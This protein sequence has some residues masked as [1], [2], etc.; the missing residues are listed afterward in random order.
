MF[1]TIRKNHQFLMLV[2]VILTILGFI[3][4]YIRANPSQFGTND[5]LSIYGRVVQRAEIDSQVRSY[6]LALALGL[7]DFV[8]DLGGLGEDENISLNNYLL[9]LLLIE[10]QSTEL[11][12]RPSDDQVLAMIKSLA[13]LQTDGAF[14][15]AKYT[16][17]VQDQLAPR[18]LTERQMEDIV[19]DSIRVKELKAI[20]TSP[21]AIGEGEVQM[22]A[23]IY[24]PVTAQVIH[25]DLEKYL[26]DS[27]VT[28]EEISAFYEKNREGLKAPETRSI[29]YVVFELP[30]QDQKLEGKDRANALQKLADQAVGVA[31]SIHDG[32]SQGSDFA[33]IAGKQSLQAQKADSIQRDGTQKGKESGLPEALVN[34]AFRLQRIGDISDL[35]Q[36]GGSFYI[37][38]LDSVSPA[39]QLEL[40]EVADRIETHLKSQKAS[41][42]AEEAADKALSGIRTA[43]NAGKNFTDAVKGVGLKVDPL[44]NIVPSDPKNNEE[45]QAFTQATLSL[46]DGEL[47][48][49]EPAPWGYF[50]VYLQ[51]RSPL[52]E[53]EWKEHQNDISKK[54]LT[55]DQ[56]LLFSEWL[57]T[58]LGTA[59]IK[60][61]PGAAS[62]GGS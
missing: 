15:P 53:S 38:T 37:V 26:K 40:A 9:N 12:I 30:E 19:R 22:A 42:V 45:Q 28:P 14:D 1:T 29:S 17:F 62:A 59:Q 13:P 27:S 55:K 21:V 18:G 7:T 5:V 36:D 56:D 60:M 44:V 51:K 20:I 47:G 33:T 32:I 2:I 46:K 3:G 43:L 48:Q 49:L 24:Q 35:I 39:H 8:S 25:F 61:L 11:G 23:R 54:L 10:H 57:H 34:G 50:A 52:T 16:S 41:K 4:L 58:S 31:K 6:R